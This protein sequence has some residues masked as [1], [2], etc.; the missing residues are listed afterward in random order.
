MKILPEKALDTRLA[1]GVARH[2]FRKWYERQLL[3]SHGHMLLALL[4]FF[5]MLASVEAFA[6][7]SGGERLLDA[8][9]GLA[10][11]AIALW[12]L[13]RYLYLLMRA[14]ALA[15]QANC[16]ECGE[17]GRFQV[18]GEDRR[19]RMTQVR[20]RRCDHPWVIADD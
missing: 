7:G 16:A 6:G 8:L 9:M 3:S 2:G 10:C 1:E 11:G 5:A 4:S 15:H 19:A 20:C 14:E 18:T 13:R 12:A 17:Y